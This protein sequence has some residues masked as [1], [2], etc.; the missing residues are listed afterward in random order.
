[1][2]CDSEEGSLT[3]RHVRCS[4]VSDVEPSNMLGPFHWAAHSGILCE[5]RV[6]RVARATA[7][8]HGAPTSLHCALRNAM[9]ACPRELST[10][11]A[12]PT[13]DKTLTSALRV[14]SFWQ[15]QHSSSPTVQSSSPTSCSS[16]LRA[17]P[18]QYVTDSSFVEQ[19]FNQRGRKA[20]AASTSAWADLWGDVWHEIDAQG[21]LGDSLS[22]R[23]VKTHTAP[24]AVCAG[25]ITRATRH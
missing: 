5:A 25:V 2:L 9:A 13:R 17:A 16:E 3:H 11:M 19:G 18:A 20:T 10:E 12:Q 7:S 8:A 22:V 1:M 15:T 4:E 6:F 21:G 23:K 14:G 24:E